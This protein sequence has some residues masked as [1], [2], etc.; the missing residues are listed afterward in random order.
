MLQKQLK[1]AFNARGVREFKSSDVPLLTTW[2]TSHLSPTLHL[3]SKWYLMHFGPSCFYYSNDKFIAKQYGSCAITFVEMMTLVL[4]C[5][6]NM[7]ICFGFNTIIRTKKYQRERIYYENQT[8]D[9]LLTVRCCIR[10][11]V[12]SRFIQRNI[13]I[14]KTYDIHT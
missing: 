4:L 5:W 9:F 11:M 7:T 2:L 1:V 8:T 12:S 14:D 6:F 3:L 13:P 10:K